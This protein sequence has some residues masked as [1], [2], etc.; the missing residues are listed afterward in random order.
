M[1]GSL[2]KDATVQVTGTANGWYRFGEGRW[3]S[4]TYLKAGTPPAPKPAPAPA[5]APAAGVVEKAIS[6]AMAQVGDAYVYGATGPDAWDCSGLTQAAY[7]N[8]GVSIARSSSAQYGSGR[9]VPLA[10]MQRGDLLFWSSNGAQSGIYH[11]AIYLGGGMKV[12]AR[13]PGWGVQHDAVYYANIMP[14]VVRLG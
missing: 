11:V 14:N 3:A 5:P 8:A 12:H 4:G 13:A 10:Q 7:R 9:L 2:A 1:I 6:F